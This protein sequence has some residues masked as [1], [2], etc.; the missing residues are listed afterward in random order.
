MNGRHREIK[1]M[2]LVLRVG[3]V[4]EGILMNTESRSLQNRVRLRAEHRVQVPEADFTQLREF[5]DR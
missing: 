5:R 1:D 3:G 2:G 4:T